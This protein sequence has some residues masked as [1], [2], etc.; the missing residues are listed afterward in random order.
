[1]FSAL[2]YTNNVF[3]KKV[4]DYFYFWKVA[5]F[6]KMVAGVEELTQYCIHTEFPGC[7]KFNS[8]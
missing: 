8:Q 3:W 1:M 7:P 5:C 4:I 2:R 6:L